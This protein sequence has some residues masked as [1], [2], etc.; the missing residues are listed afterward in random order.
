MED[1]ASQGIEIDSQ[2]TQPFEPEQINLTKKR[3]FISDR[4]DIHQSEKRQMLTRDISAMNAAM[5]Q[6][7]R[8]IEK[9]ARAEVN[10]IGTRDTSRLKEALR[11]F[12]ANIE[13]AVMNDFPAY[14]KRLSEFD[15]YYSKR[16]FGMDTLGSAI[17][18]KDSFRNEDRKIIAKW[19]VDQMNVWCTYVRTK[20]IVY[21]RRPMSDLTNKSPTNQR[22][23]YVPM[24]IKEFQSMLESVRVLTN[25]RADLDTELVLKTFRDCDP[26]R[27]PKTLNELPP[28]VRPNF[29][30]LK[31]HL[32]ELKKNYATDIRDLQKKNT[33]AAREQRDEDIIDP[34]SVAKPQTFAE[35]DYE[36]I[37]TFVSFPGA[38]MSMADMWLQHQDKKAVDN[39]IWD[40]SDGL[41]TPE[42]TL[43][44][45][46][47]LNITK[48]DLV[49]LDLTGDRMKNLREFLNH[50]FVVWYNCDVE[51]FVYWLKLMAH[52]VQ[53]RTKSEVAC[54]VSGNEGCGKTSVITNIM[55]DIIG[56][57][58][59]HLT[60]SAS[61]TTKQFNGAYAQKLAVIF[62]EVD[63]SKKSYVDALKH[64]VSTRLL[65]IEKK[66]QEIALMLAAFTVFM[67]SND[68]G[69]NIVAA[70]K[71]RRWFITW[72][73]GLEPYLVKKGI[74][75]E[76]YFNNLWGGRNE[77]KMEERCTEIRTLFAR[78]LYDIDLTD[79]NSQAIPERPTLWQKRIQTLAENDKEKYVWLQC[80]ATDDFA[81][82][83]TDN[84]D[85]D[86]LEGWLPWEN[87]RFLLGSM[88]S[89]DL[90]IKYSDKMMNNFL[91][92][93][94][95]V[96]PP[97]PADISSRIK[98]R[99]YRNGPMKAVYVGCLSDLRKAFE[100]EV[101]G[102]SWTW[103]SEEE[104]ASFDPV[105]AVQNFPMEKLE[106]NYPS[107]DWWLLKRGIK[108]N[109]KLTS[110]TVY[111]NNMHAWLYGE[112]LLPNDLWELVTQSEQY[113]Q[114][115]I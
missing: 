63:M 83:P 74:T 107:P 71:S 75:A 43:N 36:I 76:E 68:P 51:M 111:V 32:N 12:A 91:E 101:R 42:N 99:E 59:F 56:K 49:D 79:W 22:Y 25:S 62:E 86:S 57:H 46:C 64:L 72:A 48:A 38:V 70:G 77:A 80:I 60:S 31:D 90:D 108:L 8:Y 21:L 89:G 61:D 81:I 115:V 82:S 98:Y 27:R 26:D 106:A 87:L 35:M 33:L 9:H 1:G 105:K 45:F 23:V 109:T 3:N 29:K 102:V 114:D 53:K 103:M 94:T 39:V 69:A 18:S 93:I 15:D 67:F 5:G 37:E 20:G 16:M 104:K 47:G 4:E 2:V 50:V 78:L 85:W 40:P 10:Q 24:T 92:K 17:Q 58:H 100:S 54:I 11:S 19:W 44:L 113:L 73:A 34:E 95:S 7:I 41:I 30:N 65:E 110:N 88:R 96:L 112:G 55:A 28:T 97:L 84:K 66:N 13:D 14:C 52:M 6:S